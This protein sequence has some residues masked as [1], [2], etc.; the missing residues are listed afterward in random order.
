MLIH[1]HSYYSYLP[2]KYSIE[3]FARVVTGHIP[4]RATSSVR[5]P[6]RPVGFTLER[7]VCLV[8][9]SYKQ[10]NVLRLNSCTL[11]H[12]DVEVLTLVPQNVTLFGDRDFKKVIK[13]KRDKKG[14]P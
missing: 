12:S 8:N 2:E 4:W 14:G 1:D 13:L 10:V 11:L 5:K 6:E 7:T 9:I 3:Y